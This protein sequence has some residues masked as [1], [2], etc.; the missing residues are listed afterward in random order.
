[1]KK[2]FISTLL[3]LTLAFVVL[4]TASYAWFTS[5]RAVSAQG[6]SVSVALPVNIMASFESTATVNSA[7][8]FSDRLELGSFSFD[9]ENEPVVD[10]FDML[11]PVTSADGENFLYLPFK[12]ADSDGCP[13]SDVD[14]SAYILVP[15][16]IK[17]GY[18]IDVP[19]YL[20]TTISRDVDIYLS[21]I[22]IFG[23][24]TDTG[25]QSNTAITGAVRCAVSILEGE[26]T[27]TLIIAKD[28]TAQP[29]NDGN[30]DYYPVGYGAQ[31]VEFKTEDYADYES[32]YYLSHPELENPYLPTE[33]N[34]FTLKGAEMVG[35][36]AVYYTTK[37]QIKI[38]VEGS[39][40][41][42]VASSAGAYFSVALYFDVAAE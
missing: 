30:V 34:I 6:M 19:L 3:F 4:G 2:H 7:A 28:S 13:R 20:L 27:R 41:S 16:N 36:S 25:G 12:Y 15:D 24:P 29:L 9:I 35:G 32:A 22:D 17:V 39:D 38:W 37:L 14:E 33:E 42:A 5:G 18:Y 31:G 1:M 40:A 10:E 26:Q 11:V 8:G 21:G 23:L